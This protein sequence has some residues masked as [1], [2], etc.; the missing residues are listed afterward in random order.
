MLIIRA[1]EGN[2]RFSYVLRKNPLT[3][4]LNNGFKKEVGTGI[5]WGYYKNEDKE[6]H[7]RFIPSNNGREELGKVEQ[8]P[9]SHIVDPLTLKGL[10]S[11][12]LSSA[13][14]EEMEDDGP[15]ELEFFLYT[16][17]N[18]SPF[19][20]NIIDSKHKAHHIIQSFPTL[21]SSLNWF[22]SLCYYLI[23]D[24]F[25]EADY[26]KV[27]NAVNNA[28]LA[29]HPRY[30]L[31]KD[32][33]NLGHLF[34][35]PSIN[36]KSITLVGGNSSLQRRNAITQQL[37]LTKGEIRNTLID[38]GAGSLYI[39][40]TLSKYYLHTFA[41]DKTPFGYKTK[42]LAKEK[43][44]T[45]IEDSIENWK[46]SYQGSDVILSEVLEHNPKHIA[47]N[48]LNLILKDKPNRLIIT[49]PN[50][51]FNVNFL[52]D[53]REFRHEDHH[54]EPNTQD[55]YDM[56]PS[57]PNYKYELKGIGDSVDNVHIS[58]LISYTLIH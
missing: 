40:R 50:K 12:L 52:G 13:W 2:D 27:S 21:F 56:F 31:S 7:L 32:R 28:K 38:L 23:D 44:I 51:E 3:S 11:S 14:K 57:I 54:W 15:V 25:K 30:L 37:N 1:L 42:E 53:Y 47:I 49:L 9:I 10:V 39:S 5:Y 18:L 6:F 36:G 16:N 41:I 46:G 48:L 19:S 8:L 24:Y 33:D 20:V 35:H 26:I 43:G 55:I 17:K 34:S 29:Y 45:L 4:Q 22:I 58:W